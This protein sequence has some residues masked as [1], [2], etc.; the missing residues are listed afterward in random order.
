VAR[1]RSFIGSL[2]GGEEVGDDTQLPVGASVPSLL[3]NGNSAPPSFL[4]VAV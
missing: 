3:G 1:P 4:L 2:S